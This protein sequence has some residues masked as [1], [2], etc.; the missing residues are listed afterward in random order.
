MSDPIYCGLA[1]G[2]VS[3]GNQGE[4]RPCCGIVP[5]EFNSKSTISEEHILDRINNEQLRKVRRSLIAGAWPG[6]CGNCKNAES[7]GSDS[8]RTI[9]NE[10]IDNAP[11]IETI[12]PDSIKYLELSVG[13]KCNSK[14]MT[15]NPSCSDFWIEEYQY[16]TRALNPINLATVNITNN[17]VD[18]LLETFKNI[19]SINLLGGEPMFA[20]GHRLLVE[21]L[22]SSGMSKNISLSYVSNLTIFDESLV[23]IWKQF[24]SVGASLS[25]DGVGLVND[26][27]RYPA[28]FDKVEYNL[29]RYLDLVEAGEFG[30]TLSCTISIFNFV[31]YPDLVDHYVSLI[32]KYDT[33]RTKMAI[34]LNYVNNPNYFNSSLLSTEFRTSCLPR[35]AKIKEKLQSMNAHPSLLTSCDTLYAWANEPTNTDEIIVNTALDFISLSD[36]YRQR[37]IQDYIPEVWEELNKLKEKYGK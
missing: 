21:K 32:E 11:M 12:N 26:Y 1:F 14:C 10:T 18:Q 7:I 35:L 37:H 4:L 15:C 30:I 3:M 17:S 5:N 8:M 16:N 22:V 25:L 6:A 33:S 36:K 29:N 2:S 28:K 31:R 19:E 9:W 34:F 27:L 23:D 24:K 20:D 13:N